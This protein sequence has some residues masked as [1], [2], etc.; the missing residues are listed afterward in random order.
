MKVLL[1]GF[2]VDKEV[3]NEINIDKKIL[4]PETISAA[5]ARISR[6]PR[7]VNELR[8]ESKYA[9]EKARKSNENIVFGMG[10][11]SIAEHS[12][13]N[14]DI[15]GISR[16]LVELIESHRLCSY[17][18]KSQRYIKI[19]D[20]FIVPD[21][22][23][24]TRCQKVFTDTIKIQNEAYHQFYNALL[25]YYKSQNLEMTKEEELKYDNMAKEDARYVLSMSTT[26]QLGMTINARN[27]ELMVRKLLTCKL[28][29]AK[30]FAKK[31]YDIS[32]EIA[33]SLVKYIVPSEY[34]IQS[35]NKEKFSFL[36][37]KLMD[38][39]NSI[40]EETNKEINEVNVELINSPDD[41]F[42]VA[43]FLYPYVSFYISFKDF[44][45]H[46]KNNIFRIDNKFWKEVFKDLNLHNSM[47]R[48]F[49][50]ISMSFNIK[51]SASCFAQFKR[52]RM[53]SM[54]T[55]PY[56]IYYSPTIPDSF[57]FAGLKKEFENIIE[58]TNKAYSIIEKDLGSEIASY[59]LTN[60]HIRKPRSRSWWMQKYY[61]AGKGNLEWWETWTLK[62]SFKRR[63]AR[64][65]PV[66]RKK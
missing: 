27:I 55:E 63:R 50:N 43:T 13:F 28:I 1:A 5:Y 20:D 23:L 21:E 46:I 47:S 51:M 66:P 41:S 29:E 48:E 42:T 36:K 44:H 19:N 37:M 24:G 15:I 25:N 59:I 40:L 53:L 39:S 14:I 62:S 11:S 56:N 10:H 45:N 30:R 12:V 54:T 38:Y 3:L 22:I 26:A 60:A 34:E 9:V 64:K 32:G 31:L 7:P 57:V 18:E 61:K 2:N 16:L 4:T 17:T 6:D 8:E 49:E 35:N 52:H 33:P 65:A 58:I